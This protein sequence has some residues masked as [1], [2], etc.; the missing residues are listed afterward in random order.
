MSFDAIRGQDPAIRLLGGALTSGRVAS[1]YLFFG[2]EGVGKHLT[3]MAFARAV[4]CGESGGDACGSC[5]SCVRTAAGTHP[6]LIRIERQEGKTKIAIGQ[7]QDLTEQL[8]LRPI[9]GASVVAILDDVEATSLE[10]LN[11]LLKTLEEPPPGATLVLVTSTPEALP[12]TIRSR[13][14]GVRF[15]PLSRELI[16]SALAEEDLSEQERELVCVLAGGSLGRARRVLAYAFHESFSSDLGFEGLF[17][18]D[19]WER[20]V[21][22]LEG[23]RV[24]SRTE[25]R[26]RADALFRLLLGA[27]R[28]RLESSPASDTGSSA[29][30]LSRWADSVSEGIAR[31]RLG[32]DAE[33]LVKALSLKIG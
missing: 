20:A 26:E 32:L 5:P 16:A 14:Q 33:G 15:R 17:G 12:E 21:R 23:V 2:P 7:I 1:G 18:G 8:S 27:I 19:A 25:R 13:C 11:A 30:E 29:A 6:G 9:E 22:W 31:L 3:A 28:D 24:P 4:L 10:G